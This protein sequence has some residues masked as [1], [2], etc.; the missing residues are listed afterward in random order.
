MHFLLC[1][2]IF[3]CFS[4][5]IVSISLPSDLLTFS[6]ARSNLLLITFACISF[7]VLYFSSRE[8]SF[9]LVLC[10]PFLSSVCFPLLCWWCRGNSHSSHFNAHTCWYRHLPSLCLLLVNNF[11]SDNGSYSA[12]FQFLPDVRYCK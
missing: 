10:C 4:I 8:V 6:S 12:C 3:L 5:C 2:S 1:S 9:W 11:T 7:Y